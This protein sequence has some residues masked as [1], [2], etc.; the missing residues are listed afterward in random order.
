MKVLL[1]APVEQ[2]TGETIT[3]RHLAE[4]LVGEGHEVSFLASGFAAK[5]LEGSPG[6]IAGVLDSS[7]GAENLD[8]WRRVTADISPDAI[9]FADYPLLF[10]PAGVAPLVRE[11]GWEETLA[12]TESRL[13]TLDHFGFA[14]REMGLFFGPAHLSFAYQQ[15]PVLPASMEIMLPCPMHEPG[16]VSGRRGAPFRYWSVPF[17]RSNDDRRRTRARYLKE[18]DGLL[19]FHAVP[20]WAWR[21]AETFELPLYFYLGPIL[22]HYLRRLS[23]PVTIVSVNN[24]WLLQTPV[25]AKTNFVNLGV[26]P[27]EE[28]ESLLWAADLMLTENGVSISMGKAVCGLQ[29]CAA[30]KNSFRLP[31]VVERLEDPLRAWVME[32]ESQRAGS[33]YP[34]NVYPTGMVEELEKIVLYQ[35]NSLTEAFARVELF[36]GEETEAHLA[37]LLT[38]EA[39]R[40]VLLNRQQEYVRRLSLLPDGAST[41]E[42]LVGA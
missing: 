14:Q 35:D 27:V 2:G 4:N 5:F 36:G 6:S 22:D 34:F 15:F 11:P 10:F 29:P 25:D 30:L 28:F 12:T 7:D 33:I 42:Q 24:G 19:I 38:D 40:E 3:C 26:I 39:A 20:N 9:V 16:A 17:D 37:A 41:L 8:L 32:M 21:Q 1:V 23:R 13:V 31:E 18:D